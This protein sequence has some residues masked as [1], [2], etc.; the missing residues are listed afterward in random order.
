MIYVVSLVLLFLL[1]IRFPR[2]QPIVHIIHRRHGV[3]AV[4]CFRALEKTITRAN[5]LARDINYLRA[6]LC[7]EVVPKFLRIKLY[8]RTLER[9]PNCKAWQMNLLKKEIQRQDRELSRKSVEL[10]RIK[11]QFAG[12]VGSLD[13]SCVNLWLNNKQDLINRNTDRIH[14]RKLQRLGISPISQKLDVDKVIF[15][16]SDYNLSNAEKRILLLG[17]DFG[18]PI[19]K[20]YYHKYFLDF[21]K[22]YQALEK[23]PIFHFTDNAKSQFLSQ[24]KFISNKFYYDFKFCKFSSP[25]FKKEDFSTL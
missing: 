21:E 8:R 12:I 4:K 23:F 9:S 3:Q 16:H 10:S 20:L 13:S 15:N 25:L 17:M 14:S 18:L 11:A 2:N 7:Y 19:T 6:C 1:R 24:L 5:K 22:L